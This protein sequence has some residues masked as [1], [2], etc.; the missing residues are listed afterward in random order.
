MP[1]RPRVRKPKPR[2]E[3]RRAVLLLAMVG[4]ALALASLPLPWRVNAEIFS[5]RELA[6]VE[7]KVYPYLVLMGGLLV[8]AGSA[9][10]FFSRSE[11]VARGLGA[12]TLMGGL[13]VIAGGLWGLNDFVCKWSYGLYLS[14]I[15]GLAGMFG[16]YGALVPR[17]V[18]GL[19]RR[20]RRRS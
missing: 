7:M 9:G 14:L 17:R 12:L 8:L 5:G 18:E 4:G 11:Y 13:L 3:T 6:A 1:R 16:S 10:G 19:R 20:P 15:A 2:W